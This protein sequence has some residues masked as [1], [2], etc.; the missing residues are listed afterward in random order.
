MSGDFVL[1]VRRSMLIWAKN[2]PVLVD[3]IPAASMYPGTVP[4]ART[5]PFSRVGSILPAPFRA[6]GLNASASRVNWQAFTK[7]LMEGDA[8]IETAE[9]RAHKIGSAIKDAF[10]GK[11]LTLEDGHKLLLTWIASSPRA[12]GDEA[13]AW[14]T[15][16]TFL[17]EVLAN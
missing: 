4:A 10:D 13:E 15:T 17:A 16:V 5:F 3:L 7:P 9:D 8:I 14:M 12:D 2:W 6:S 11:T 1:P